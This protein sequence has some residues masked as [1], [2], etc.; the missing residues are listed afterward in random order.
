[1]NIVYENNE[2]LMKRGKGSIDI[3]YENHKFF[4]RGINSSQNVLFIFLNLI[5]LLFHH[6]LIKTKQLILN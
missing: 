1:M 4:I 2:E 5:H 3:F 6:I